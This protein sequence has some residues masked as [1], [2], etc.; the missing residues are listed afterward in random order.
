[1]P[2]GSYSYQNLIDD[3]SR[4][5]GSVKNILRIVN[6]AARFVV[7]DVDLRSTKRKAYLSPSLYKKQYDYQAPTDLK[8]WGVIDI[9][10]VEGRR[11]SD[12]FNLT[13][14]EYFD[15]NKTYNKNLIAIEDASL[16]KKLRISAEL[17]GDD[18]QVIIHQ[19]DTTRIAGD[20]SVGSWTVSL[21]ASNLT[22]DRDVFINGKAS[23]NFDMDQAGTTTV[24]G[25]IQNS[26]FDAIDLSDYLN[27]SVFAYVWIPET[28][29]GSGIVDADLDGFTLRIGSSSTVYFER[30]V[31]VTNENLAF[32]PGWNLLRFHLSAATET[33][34]VDLDTVDYVRLAVDRGATGTMAL[35]DW[36]LDFIVA[37]RGVSHEV[38]YLTKYPWQN[39][40]GT[41]YLENSTATTDRINA[42][43]E[44]YEGFIL[45]TKE[46]IAMDLKNFDFDDVKQYRTLYENWKAKYMLKYPSE[47]LLLIQSYKNFSNDPG[48]SWL[49]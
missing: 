18:S 38:W 3:S 15:R 19:C 44:E 20:S 5:A 47:R 8:E 45:K 31:T 30:A 14:N 24:A 42:D 35:K 48:E 6:R 12:K 49:N 29:A 27:G 36:R 41:S 9:R 16:F 26:T 4:D 22:V 13:T 10:R 2:V 28:S 43:T 7:N 39:S 34:T 17:R 21:D 23:L 46:L 1:L 32:H 37:R 25:Y 40:A 11:V 33:G